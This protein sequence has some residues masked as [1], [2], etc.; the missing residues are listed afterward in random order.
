MNK[1]MNGLKTAT[2]YTLTENG[3]VTHKSTLNGLMDLFALGG[4]YRNRSDADCITLFKTAFV[5]DPIH[6]LKCLFYLRDVRG[7]QGERRF[8]RVVI[9]DLATSETEAMR[10]NLQYVPEF[11]RWDDLYA[12]VGTPLEKDA[13]DLMYH[14]LALDVECK[15]PSLLGKWLKSENTSSHESRV[16]GEK[17]RMA[18]HM[19]PKQ[20]RKTLSTLRGRIRI[21]ERLMSENRWDEIEFDKIPSR[22]GII[23][24]NA[25]ARRDLIK[26]KYEKFAKDKTT[27]V[28]AGALYP[29]DIA[30]RAFASRYMSLEAPER[31]MLQKYWDCL[32][33]YFN[34]RKENAIAVVDVS[35]SMNGIPMEAA[36]SLGAYM[37][38]KAHGPFAGHFITFS[39]APHLVQFKGADI[40]DK[41]NRCV[42]ADWGMNT[43][44]EAVFNLLLNT[45]IK[46]KCSAE[47]MPDRIYIFSDMEFDQCMTFGPSST[48]RWGY[49]DAGRL[50]SN[51]AAVETLMESIASKWAAYGYKL[52][53]VVFWNLNARHDN[54][55]AIGPGF[56]YVSGFSPVMMETI[57]SGKDG[58]DLML[59]KLDSE[60]YAC[61][62]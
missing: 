11:G 53:S 7:G 25:F 43:N 57:L 28:N 16:L 54:I 49:P 10:R 8:F 40:V 14:Q 50:L 30:H 20:Y 62:Q 29:H 38:D 23:Y 5:E 52:P 9:R 47:D 36:V 46:N 2:N 59:E 12:F 61:I 18:F 41:F 37:A 3:A 6:A 51:N 60:R 31:V 4:A 33:D 24:R 32:P 26:E 19:T 35:G 15:T 44:L 27:K 17:T 39:A 34:G 48:D 56:S 42:E 22:A 21:V 58:I 45:A 13:F 1:L 55:P